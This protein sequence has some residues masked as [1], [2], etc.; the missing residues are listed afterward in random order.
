M[1]KISV[2]SYIDPD[3]VVSLTQKLVRIPSESPA[4][5]ERSRN[6]T[7]IVELIVNEFKSMGLNPELFTILEGRPNIAVWLHGSQ[8]GPTYMLYSHCDTGVVPDNEMPDWDYDPFG[9]EI[10]DGQL[11]GR[12]AAD[13]KGGVAGI[14]A[15]TKA[16]VESGVKFKG[17]LIVLISTASEAGSPGGVV[18]MVKTGMMG[19]SGKFNPDA[20]IV[21]DC[22]DRKI[23]RFFK[24]RVWHEFKIKGKPVHAC[25]PDAGINAI[26]KASTVIAALKKADFLK[27][28]HDYLGH[29]TLAVTNIEGGTALNA[30]PGRC[31]FTTDMRIVPGQ[32]VAG[33]TAKMQAMLESLM[34]EDPELQVELNI[35]PNAVKDI[36]E[37]PEDSKVVET[38]YKAME[39]V[40]GKA[41]F[42]PGVESPGAVTFFTQAN[43]PA[44]FFGPGSIWKA[45][46]PNES[47]ELSR[48]DQM[49]KIYALAALNFLGV[50]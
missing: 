32:T 6:R 36:I 19:N 29:C 2:L 3:Y 47:I 43:I 4:I 25:E 37:I 17:T 26:E 33:L 45:H 15:A 50:E 14:I 30:V 11:Y 38:A 21:A 28:S 12:G 41:E 24:G 27:E 44:I 9:G 40:L 13:T 7:D 8:P 34:K 5:K 35:L 18:D 39:Q 48:L 1:D 31:R 49:A 42:M 23:V 46:I 16:I 22:S 10:I 20:A